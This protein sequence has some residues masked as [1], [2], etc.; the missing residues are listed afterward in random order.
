MEFKIPM[1]KLCKS[2]QGMFVHSF[3]GPSLETIVT[4]SLLSSK[5]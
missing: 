2:V 5:D 4:L 3:Q 1:P